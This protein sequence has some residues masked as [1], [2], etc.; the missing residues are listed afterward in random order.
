MK[1]LVLSAILALPGTSHASTAA[2]TRATEVAAKQP[3]IQAILKSLKAEASSI[4]DAKRRQEALVALDKP[5]FAVVAGRRASESEIVS[6]LQA[7]ELLDLG[8]T[9]PLF[10]KHEPMPFIAAPGGKWNAHHSYPGGLVYH[11]SFN[12]RTGLALADNYARVYGVQPSRDMIRLAA[13]WHDAAKPMTFSWNDDG[14]LNREEER[15]AGTGAHHIWAV[16]EAVYRGLPRDLIVAIASAH[17][18]PSPGSGLEDLLKF[19]RAGSIIAGKPFEDAGLSAD[20]SRLASLPPMEAF[21]NRIDDHDYVFTDVS[22][23]NV[24]EAVDRVL[25][26]TGDFW[27]RNEILAR[28]GDVALY[29]VLLRDG[30]AGIERVIRKK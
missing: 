1:L 16:A 23:P 28:D 12:L 30:P 2:D 14:S 3:R 9:G 13:I 18:A 10:P 20:G 29:P 24:A 27:K 17:G 15:I 5:V 19:L 7:A 8:F 22:L 4:R 21:I 26:A 25:G 6:K 11:T